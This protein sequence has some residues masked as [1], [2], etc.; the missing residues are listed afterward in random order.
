MSKAK[1]RIRELAAWGLDQDEYRSAAYRG[2]PDIARAL[3]TTRAPFEVASALVESGGCGLREQFAGQQA[4]AD[5]QAE[6][7]GIHW[8]LGVVDLRVLQAFQRRIVV[9]PTAP[10]LR[11]PDFDFLNDALVI[12]YH[13]S[14]LSK[15]LRI[16]VEG[17]YILGGKTL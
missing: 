6:M 3:V 17:T 16:T 5:L 11:L 8:F 9:D 14:P 2:G 4:C 13:R 10:D 1:M 15:T 7:R 12:E